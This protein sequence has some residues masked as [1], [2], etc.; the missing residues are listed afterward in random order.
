MI[1]ELA[2]EL[3]SSPSFI[4][5][6]FV[7]NT[8]GIILVLILKFSKWVP[9]TSSVKDFL[10]VVLSLLAGRYLIPLLPIGREGTIPNDRQGFPQSLD[11][12]R[13]RDEV[14]SCLK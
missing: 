12:T 6:V 4:L 2:I 1:H 7:V 13:F 9:S 3:M 5:T 11:R 10:M 14:V 8:I